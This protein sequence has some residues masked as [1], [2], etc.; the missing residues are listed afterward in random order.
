VLYYQWKVVIQ[1]QFMTMDEVAKA[2]A[3]HRST[4]ER[5][6]KS[7]QLRAIKVN[8]AVRIPEDSFQEFVRRSVK[9]TKADKPQAV[10][11]E[12]MFKG[13]GPIP[14]EAIDEVIAEWDKTE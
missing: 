6:I 13:G 8:S 7:G 14:A 12:G 3:V 11:L 4:V 5:L 10:S 9:G 1:V 2:L